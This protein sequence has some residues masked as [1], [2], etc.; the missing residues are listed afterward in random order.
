MMGTLAALWAAFKAYDWVKFIARNWKWIVGGLTVAA[1]LAYIGWLNFWMDHY[2]NATRDL[3]RDLGSAV[4]A[5]SELNQA[6]KQLNT[7]KIASEKALADKLARKNYE[8]DRLGKIVQN[9][10]AQEKSNACVSSPS[11]RAVLDSLRGSK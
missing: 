1:L 6:F 5:N 2:H 10:M 11:V 8:A 9:V 4:K 7:E 3:E